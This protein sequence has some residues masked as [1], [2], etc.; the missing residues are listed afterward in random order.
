LEE[1][2][3]SLTGRRGVALVVNLTGGRQGR[4]RGGGSDRGL[5]GSSKQ[6]GKRWAVTGST[7]SGHEAV[8]LPNAGELL[9][10][11]NGGSRASHRA[12]KK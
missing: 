10:S 12:E 1:D 8:E 2:G 11:A 9:G 5:L 6:K 3:E 4:A 7:T